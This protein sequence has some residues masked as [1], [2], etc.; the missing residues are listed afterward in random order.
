MGSDE[1]TC[2]AAGCCWQPVSSDHSNEKSAMGI[3]WCYYTKDHPNPCKSFNLKA[4]KPGGFLDNDSALP[5]KMY[6]LFVGNLDIQGSGAVVAAPDKNTPGGSYYYHWERDGALSM[7]TFLDLNLDKGL[8]ALREKM[9]HYMSWIKTVQSQPDPNDIDVRTEPKYTIPDGKPYTGGWCRPQT[10]G[11]A[12]RGNTVS[13]Y[14]LLLLKNGEKD[15]AGE[16]YDLVKNDMEWVKAN[17][18]TGNG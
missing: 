2:G 15:R 8:D 18:A 1:E 10:D 6:E 9:D 11:P 5:K 3:P 16:L 13:Q 14:G 12:L 4:D 17:W 7:K